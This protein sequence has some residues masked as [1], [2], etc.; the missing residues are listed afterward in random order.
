MS[1]FLPYLAELAPE[2]YAE[3]SPELARLR[4]LT[5]GEWAT[6]VTERTAIEARVMVTDRMRVHR[7]DGR[8]VHT[9]GLPYHGGD[10]GLAR[11]D[12]AN[13]LVTIVLDQNVHISEF[14][15]A[16][17]DI[18]PGRRPRGPALLAFVDEYRRRA[19]ASTEAVR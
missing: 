10:K 16:T 11:G 17:A 9:I 14:K 12:S 4:G 19:A 13:D 8:D 6:I 5:H 1:R 18:Q 7:L 3:V 15:A 2:M